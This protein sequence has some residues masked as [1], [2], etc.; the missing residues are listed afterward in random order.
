MAGTTHR[1]AEFIEA[2]D[3]MIKDHENS[4]IVNGDCNVNCMY[5][6]NNVSIFPPARC[7]VS[8]P[9]IKNLNLTLTRGINT[10]ICGRGNCGKTSILRVIK[11]LWPIKQG[12]LWMSDIIKTYP[13]RVMY[14]PQKPLLTVGSLRRQLMYPETISECVTCKDEQIINYLEK[15]QVQE[16]L[17]RTGGL[18]EEVDWNWYNVLSPS[19]AHRL[20]L[21]RKHNHEEADTLIPLHCLN[22]A[23]SKPGCSIDVFT[24]DTDVYVLLIYIFSFLLPPCK[25]YMHAGRGK[26]YRVLDI[27]ES[28]RKIGSRKCN[29]LLG[30]HAFTGSDWGGKFSGITKRKWMKL[31]LEL[32]DSDEIL[33]L[34]LVHGISTPVGHGWEDKDTSIMPIMCLK[35]LAPQA[36][37]ELIKCGCKGK[38][39]KRQCS[40]LRNN[41]H[42]TPA[43]LCGDCHN[44]DDAEKSADDGIGDESSSDET[45][46]EEF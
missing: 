2:L 11:G 14:L 41:L 9:I 40:C 33:D 19:E 46:D 42:C 6:F 26:S 44:Q 15:F 36:L 38:C 13:K 32:D 22:A 17:W 12:E 18:D 37:L 25:L 1:V 35:S 29:A 10:L 7:D 39:D 8:K 5:E 45:G 34:I 4:N 31:F 21:V 43:C 3:K 24:V 20:S 27:E 30:M 28:C 23:S 16:L